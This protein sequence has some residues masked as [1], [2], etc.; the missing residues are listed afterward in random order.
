MFAMASDS[1]TAYFT[2]SICRQNDSGIINSTSRLKV[3]ILLSN[4]EVSPV[5]LFLSMPVFTHV[6][7]LVGN[8]ASLCILINARD[9]WPAT[10]LTDLVT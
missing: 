9:L 4:S 7:I 6:S 5:F 8:F 2:S 10:P 1:L 3:F